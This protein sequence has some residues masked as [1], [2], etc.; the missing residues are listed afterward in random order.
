M[1]E[2]RY[3]GFDTHNKMMSAHSHVFCTK[4]KNVQHTK[5]IKFHNWS[6][7]Y[8]NKMIIR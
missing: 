8:N 4:K 2:K 1:Q 3:S 7:Q 5:S 6:T